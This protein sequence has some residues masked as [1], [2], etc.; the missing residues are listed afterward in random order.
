MSNLAERQLQATREIIG[1]VATKLEADLSLQLWNGEVLPLGPGARDDIRIVVKSPGVIRRILL[2]PG[3]MTLFELYAGGDVDISGGSMLEA[4]ARW[5]HIKA[6][7]LPKTVDKVFIARKLWPFLF[8]AR[9]SDKIAAH[10]WDKQ[11]EDR[12]EKG[13]D[14][15]SLVSFHYDVSN[16]FYKLFL[17]PEMVYS[18]AYYARENMDLA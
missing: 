14:D 3:L 5:D 2:R 18:C 9:A 15:K 10:G 6:L 16:D 13:R 17:D 11:V 12:I 4:V 7:R 8:T 1:H